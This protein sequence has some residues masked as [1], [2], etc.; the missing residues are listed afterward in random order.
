MKENAA[1]HHHHHHDMMTL[2]ERVGGTEQGRKI[3]T[4]F[5]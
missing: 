4:Y 2:I 3:P 1:D 5:L